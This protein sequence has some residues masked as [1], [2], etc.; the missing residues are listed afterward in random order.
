MPR[1]RCT[2]WPDAHGVP[3]STRVEAR[4]FVVSIVPTL[5]GPGRL[6]DRAFFVTRT[7]DVQALQS[8][9]PWHFGCTFISWRK[10]SEESAGT[11]G[12]SR[13]AVLVGGRISYT[14]HHV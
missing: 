3:G 7:L 10:L 11:R 2:R 5:L 14:T 1:R 12:C 4:R 6:V 13:V 8:R 9:F